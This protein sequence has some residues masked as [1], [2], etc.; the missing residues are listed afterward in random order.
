[1]SKNILIVSEFFPPIIK[2]GVAA[3]VFSLAKSLQNSE[4]NVIVLTIKGE[5]EEKF[6]ALKLMG[7]ISGNTITILIEKYQ[8]Y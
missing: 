5:S 4:N 6:A 8:L 2:G 3:S 7:P 1:M